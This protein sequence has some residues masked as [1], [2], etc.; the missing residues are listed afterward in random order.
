MPR[1][2]SGRRRT[3]AAAVVAKRVVFARLRDRAA[4]GHESE[5]SASRRRRRQGAE[6]ARR[7]GVSRVVLGRELSVRE[8]GQVG[9]RQR[10]LIMIMIIII[11]NNNN[12]KKKK[13]KKM[14][15]KKMKKCLH[16]RGHVQI[17]T[18]AAAAAATCPFTRPDPQG[19]PSRFSPHRNNT[20][21]IRVR[22]NNV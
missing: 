11:N 18:A 3:A 13:K 6:F 15:M 8:I 21:T 16:P 19:R 2:P 7:H 10:V 5:G 14:E 1:L 12:K 4:A 22:L 17:R 9:R 20:Y